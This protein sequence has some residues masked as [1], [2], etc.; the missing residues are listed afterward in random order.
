LV[1]WPNIGH[2][3]GR[4]GDLVMLAPPF[5]VTEDHIDEMVVLLTRALRDATDRVGATK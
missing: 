4:S 1:V 5:V 2:A 3:D